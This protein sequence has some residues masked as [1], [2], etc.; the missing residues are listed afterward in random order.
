MAIQPDPSAPIPNKFTAAVRTAFLLALVESGTIRGAAARAGVSHVTVYQ[1]AKDDETFRAAIDQAR[2]EWEQSLVEAIA[3][4]GVQGEVIQRR[5]GGKTIKP[6]DWR[7]LAWLL[8][9]SPATREAYAGI[10]RQKVELGGAA[11]LPPIQTNHA[12]TQQIEIGPETMERLARVV[13]VLL[14]A[15]KIRLPDPGETV[16]DGQAEDVGD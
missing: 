6:G 3:K 16:I 9:H 12:E 14:A 10:L 1:H 2:H 8:E 4:A 11:D 13:Q 5:G 15:G 7:A